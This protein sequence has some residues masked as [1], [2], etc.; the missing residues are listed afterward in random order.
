MQVLGYQGQKGTELDR[1]WREAG[2]KPCSRTIAA[3][4][5]PHSSIWMLCTAGPTPPDGLLLEEAED[6]TA[7]KLCS[8]AW[9]AESS[10]C[11]DFPAFC[12]VAGRKVARAAHQ[13]GA[14]IRQDR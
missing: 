3:V 2:K 9:L 10:M 13:S 1:D 14:G 6:C 7:K 4:Y 12:M 8:L 11:T 5:R